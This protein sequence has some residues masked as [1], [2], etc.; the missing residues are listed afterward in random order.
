MFCFACSYVA[1]IWRRSRLLSQRK[2]KKKKEKISV[3]LL[4]RGSR[5][6]PKISA[7]HSRWIVCNFL[8]IACHMPA[9]KLISFWFNF[10]CVWFKL[11]SFEWMKGK[12]ICKLF[13][14]IVNQSYVFLLLYYKFKNLWKVERRDWWL[15]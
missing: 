10:A 6:P 9:R 13:F 3:I 14:Y 15:N 7:C 12:N 1:T 8:W 11:L 5:V 4:L 2:K